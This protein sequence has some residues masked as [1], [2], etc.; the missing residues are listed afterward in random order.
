MNGADTEGA[1]Q[2]KKAD[3]RKAPRPEVQIYRP[4]MLKQG[5][6]IT[7]NA[8][9]QDEEISSKNR[10][11]RQPP[12]SPGRDRFEYRTYENSNRR[13]QREDARN[14]DSGSTTPE[15]H[16]HDDYRR[17]RGGGMDRR[18]NRRGPP[19]EYSY[20]GSR[21]DLASEAS[22]ATRA[23]GYNS[24][25][26]LLETRPRPGGYLDQRIGQKPN[27]RPR[28]DRG[29][30]RGNDRQLNRMNRPQF[31]RNTDRA[32]MRAETMQ[33]RRGGGRGVRNRNDSLNSTQSERPASL[34]VD[35]SDRYDETRSV[36]GAPSE[37]PSSQGLSFAEL[38][39]SFDSMGS[40]NW[41]E[42]VQED[43][44]TENEAAQSNDALELKARLQASNREHEGET[45][46]RRREKAP[47]G[48]IT[49]GG[50]GQRMRRDSDRSSSVADS[51]VEERSDSESRDETFGEESERE[52][53]LTPTRL[54]SPEPSESIPELSEDVKDLPNLRPEGKG[55][56]K[57]RISYVND[58]AITN[59]PTKGDKKLESMENI[60]KNERTPTEETTKVRDPMQRLNRLKGRVSLP[61]EPYQPPAMRIKE[62]STT[63]SSDST[64]RASIDENR[65]RSQ[66]MVVSSSKEREST[67]RND[68][69]STMKVLSRKEKETT[70]THSSYQK[71]KEQFGEKITSINDQMDSLIPQIAARDV[72]SAKKA[73]ELSTKLSE[74]YYDFLTKD[75]VFTFTMNLET[76]LWKQAYYKIIE[77]LR[78]GSNSVREAAGK[79]RDILRTVITNGI[80]YYKRLFALYENE[81]SFK[82]SDALFW[83][84][85]FSTD[86]LKSAHD[87]P[88]PLTRFDSPHE[89]A[90]LKSL[91]RHHVSLGNLYRYLAIVEASE[92]FGRSQCSYLFATQ[93]WPES[94]LAYNQLAILA[95]NMMLYRSRLSKLSTPVLSDR[96][97][98]RVIDET[99]YLV[100]AISAQFPFETAKDRMIQRLSAMIRKIE[101]Y[102]PVLDKEFG[103]AQDEIDAALRKDQPIEIWVHRDGQMMKK[104]D[105]EV[106]EDEI[107][108][109]ICQQSPSTVQRRC[110]SYLV[111]VAAMLHTKINF[112][113]FSSVSSRALA[114]LAAN[115]ELGDSRLSAQQLAQLSSVFIF[116]VTN[117]QTNKETDTLTYQ[118]QMSFSFLLSFFG[119][120]LRPLAAASSSVASWLENEEL[121]PQ[122]VIR[123]LP[124]LSLLSYWMS[125]AD[126]K[127]AFR[128]IN[129][130]EP[131]VSPFFQVD[132][133]GFLAQIANTLDAE[134]NA[135]RF[136]KSTSTDSDS[137]VKVL[138]E[139]NLVSSFCNVF[140]SPPP[141]LNISTHSDNSSAQRFAFHFRLLGLLSFARFLDESK[142]SCFGF[143]HE[144]KRFTHRGLNSTDGESFE[145]EKKQGLLKKKNEETMRENL[146]QNETKRKNRVL[147]VKPLQLV[148]DT[149]GFVDHLEL[150]TKIVS[151]KHYTLLVPTIVID[152]LTGLALAPRPTENEEHAEFVHAQAKVAAQWLK[153]QCKLKPK[154]ISVL[155]SR[156]E[157][158]KLMMVN[159]ESTRGD[160]RN[161]NDDRIVESCSSFAE[162]CILPPITNDQVQNLP[163]DSDVIL[164]GVVLLTEDR[165]VQ[166][167]A[168][169]QSIPTRTLASF[170][171]WASL[172]GR[173][174]EVN[175]LRGLLLVL[176]DQT[177]E[178]MRQLETMR[179]GAFSLGALHALRFAHMKAKNPDKESLK[180]I[181]N[182]LGK[183]QKSAT[184]E[185]L[186]GAAHIL[187][188]LNQASKARTFAERALENDVENPKYLCVMGWIEY[189]LGRDLK[190][191]QKCFEDSSTKLYP[192]AFIG[193]VALLADRHAPQEMAIVA[194]ELY[195]QS[196]TFVPSVLEMARA[197]SISNQ[198]EQL[199]TQLNNALIVQS[200]CLAAHLLLA[201]NAVCVKGGQT[202]VETALGDLFSAFE[203]M[204]SLNH[205]LAYSLADLFIRC[206]VRNAT[207]SQFC[208]KL[209]DKAL[210]LDRRPEY[211]A[212]AVRLL[213]HNDD[214]KGGL[215]VAKELITIGSEEPRAL[216]GIGLCYLACGRAA[217]AASQYSFVKEA[218]TN[219]RENPL[220]M[221][222][223]ALVA[224][225]HDNSFDQFFSNIKNVVDTHLANVPNNASGEELIKALDPAFLVDVALQLLDYAPPSP[226]KSPDPILKEADRVLAAVHEHCQGLTEVT[227]LLAKVR[228]L[229]GDSDGAEKLVDKCLDRNETVADAYL[230]KA[231]IKVEKGKVEDAEQC[232]D[233]GLSFNF[234]VRDSCLYHLIKAK[235]LKKRGE[236]EK[237]VEV[238]KS[239]V[240]LPRQEKNVSINLLSR[241]KS[242]DVNRIS[243]H[244][245]LVDSL[246]ALKK[247]EEAER[248]MKE[249]QNQWKGRPEA[250][251][252]LLTHAQ[253]LI[254]KGD[255]DAALTIL[256]RV[257]P[258]QANYQAARLKM[259]QIYLD[260]KKD[261]RMFTI[262]Y[263]ELLENDPSPATYALLGD[264]YMKVQN[265]SKAIE[266]YE[267]ALKANPKDHILAQKIGEAYVQCHL[268]AKAVN[269]YEAAVKSAKDNQMR[270]KLSNLL[271]LLG[272]FEKCERVL[273]DPLEKEPNPSD[274]T[275][276]ASHVSYWML[277]SKLHFENGNWQEAIDDLDKAKSLQLRLLG[278]G[279]GNTLQIK[280]EAAK[281]CCNLAELHTNR[282]ELTRAVELYKEAVQLNETDIKTILALAQLYLTMGKLHLCNQQCQVALNIEKN[283]DEATLMMADLL[284][285][286]NEGDQAVVHFAQLLERYPNHYHALARTIE[287]SWRSGDVDL[288]E[289]HL[290]RALENNPRAT[291]DAG[292]NY[293]KGLHEWYSGEPNASLQAF[294]RAR[295][296]LEWGERAIYNM[297]EICLNPENEVLGGEVLDQADDSTDTASRQIGMQTA[298]KFL[299]ELRF[300]PGLDIRYSL[301]ENFILVSSGNKNSMQQALN[302]LLDMIGIEGERVQSVGAVLGAA[303]AYML[304]KQ[305]QKAKQT[306][307]RV[308]GHPW[309]I[310]DADYL[311][312]CW[313]LLADLYIN[314]NKADQATAILRTVLMHNASSIRA[315]EFMGFLKE[316]EQK[317][318]DASANYEEAWR[319]CKQRNPAIGYK[320]AYNYMKSKKIFDCIEVCHKVLQQYPSYPKIKKEIMD[321]A[322]L[323]IRS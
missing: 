316:K 122:K 54:R 1:A 267:K 300:K 309:T 312:K 119:V 6:D 226:T 166:I 82:I 153:D 97:Q 168:S 216:L 208:R 211:L 299:K 187:C 38:C 322:R 136:L 154:N 68:Q 84:K 98:S 244:L 151:S 77:S 202:N 240:R 159:E 12:R 2:E 144:T 79:L 258:N 43:F 157:M 80:S 71:I 225:F 199:V 7:L 242:E 296:D 193:R 8:A 39:A 23:S 205:Q 281:I 227:Y 222:L 295:R 224:K 158:M 86:D 321:K 215:E 171:K 87:G 198:W 63:A 126:A 282:R 303:R 294:N 179:N 298:E 204:E 156:G 33:R 52:G 60:K 149:N 109:R 217:D 273:K 22:Y 249:A 141:A 11:P 203:S 256:N 301:M 30:D 314:Q 15:S 173:D 257:Q 221:F 311:E 132:T 163:S 255:A 243:V 121:T 270:L 115:L 17:T 191:A 75:I 49:R 37:A 194:Q 266:V 241:G 220:C 308:V 291:V 16:H 129:V 285:M 147:L 32:S 319:L 116:L 59:E 278:R 85:G 254:S 307:K 310:D 55:R 235:V 188:L 228:Y 234:A 135:G 108:S 230:L 90:A 120:L 305:T 29:N 112:N 297:I 250:E 88:S 155:T 125:S 145:D 50:Y 279:E 44:A 306:L 118:Q 94:G 66:E 223:G 123:V 293:C 92:D 265:P 170:V 259:A 89:K 104:E 189:Q 206:A 184:S 180:E 26:S 127:K 93:I 110:V 67:S 280:K 172:E 219:L 165:G 271:F 83:P 304:L 72:S 34:Y 128:S 152:E 262:C 292:Y 176:L 70:E 134:D 45:G 196:P 252:L 246:Q 190:A 137:G 251:Q 248:I 236:H 69:Q 81:F 139:M 106:I 245:E 73:V 14:G 24:T 28:N 78:S 102:E 162:S 124:S 209:L 96:R 65:E 140:P 161:I 36:G 61:A 274:L 290:R 275:T 57:G 19:S 18:G 201:L 264:A 4:G 289:K 286:K 10:G 175:L 261:R 237:A 101:K 100:R 315:F 212:L 56:W 182:D 27:E 313:L 35:T 133:W 105:E 130:V 231:Q 164:R 111:G 9:A 117:V 247:T 207:T 53:E 74:V 143:D 113:Q 195:R 21:D 276:I 150:I 5:V 64:P 131:L 58:D 148:P 197:L 62:R 287:L 260:E 25:Q 40:M 46:E 47:R 146:A 51:I 253:I 99:Y 320:L 302:N 20:N 169:A 218:H 138:P 277:L 323:M 232:L 91:S 288:A 318:I 42:V 263:K 213:I 200:E 192:D 317:W 181:D 41:S 107:I 186:F 238:L 283:N 272:N 167:K 233:T 229:S 185:N 103:K 178:G 268:Y 214:A 31:E 269:Y 3:R 210:A 142:L 183:E 13:R 284:Y 76:H 239:A 174:D 114:F 48:I 160:L 177:A 95:Y